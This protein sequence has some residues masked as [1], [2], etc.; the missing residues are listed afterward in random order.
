M[1]SFHV[2][3]LFESFLSTPR[4]K[5]VHFIS[6]SIVFHQNGY[7]MYFNKLLFRDNFH[8]SDVIKL[9]HYILKL[10]INKPKV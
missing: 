6:L 8:D 3:F 9:F 10:A 2:Y 1:I 7:K 4:M 5:P